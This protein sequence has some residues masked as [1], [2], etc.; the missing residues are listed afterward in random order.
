MTRLLTAHHL[1]VELVE[2]RF[3]EFFDAF[4]NR[5]GRFFLFDLF[6]DEIPEKQFDGP[7]FLSDRQRNDV[8]NHFGY[9][10]FV[11]VNGFEYVGEVFPRARRVF[12]LAHR[13]GTAALHEEGCHF[14]GVFVFFFRLFSEPV[15]E[16]V[17]AVLFAVERHGRVEAGG[18]KFSRDL[19]IDRFFEFFSQVHDICFF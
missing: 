6:A 5:G 18:P 4:S 2:V 8:V 15:G 12:R 11:R 1:L 19:L 3:A 17:Q 7:V 16:A 14:V 13:D 9:F 10:A